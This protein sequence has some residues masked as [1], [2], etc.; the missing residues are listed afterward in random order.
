MA[1]VVFMVLQTQM[2][3]EPLIFS[4]TSEAIIE[5]GGRFDFSC[6]TPKTLLCSYKIYNMGADVMGW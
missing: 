5:Q 1:T 2:Q 6:S 4:S 3:E